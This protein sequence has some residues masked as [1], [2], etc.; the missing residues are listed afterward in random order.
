MNRTELRARVAIRPP[1]SD[2]GA[3]TEIG[4][5]ISTLADVPAH[6]EMFAIAGL[7]S[8]TTRHRAARRGRNPRAGEAVAIAPNGGRPSVWCRPSVSLQSVAKR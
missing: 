7:G 8:S 2:R 6:S 1:L 4:A 5:V 3:A